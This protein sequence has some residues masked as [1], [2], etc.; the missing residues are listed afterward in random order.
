MRPRAEK[1]AKGMG[2]KICLTC[3]S[4]KQKWSRRKVPLEQLDGRRVKQDGYLFWVC[5]SCQKQ[6]D[7]ELAIALCTG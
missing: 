3:R 2:W 6:Y 7:A 1:E 4:A 5:P